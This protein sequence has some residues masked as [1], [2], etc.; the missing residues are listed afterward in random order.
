MSL[1]FLKDGDWFYNFLPEKEKRELSLQKIDVSFSMKR[2]QDTISIVGN[3]KTIANVECY[4]CLEVTSLPLKSEFRYTLV[5]GG[6]EKRE[7]LELSPEDMEFGY[8]QDDAIDLDQI[9]FEQIVLQIPIKVLCKDSCKGLC[10]HCGINLNMASCDCHAGFV[11]ERLAVLE[12][13]KVRN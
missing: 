9:I 12:K 11:N 1:Q 2:L 6:D 3:I 4:R 13:I 5:P 10:P 7:E 8:Y